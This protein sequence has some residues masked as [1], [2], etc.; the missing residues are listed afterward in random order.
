MNGYC[1][2]NHEFF[3]EGLAPIGEGGGVLPRSNSNLG[4]AIIQS[5]GTFDTFISQFL[6]KNNSEVPG[7]SWEWLAYNKNTGEL[8]M[9]NK[10]N[11]EV[12]CDPPSVELVPLLT[13]DIWLDDYQVKNLHSRKDLPD[14]KLEI[15][16]IINWKKVAERYAEAK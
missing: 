5:F 14:P 2:I 11:Y 7:S 15:L 4:K 6:G 12:W 13:T 9:K 10:E 3:W 8:E 16:K 1:V